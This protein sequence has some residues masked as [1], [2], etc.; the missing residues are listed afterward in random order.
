MKRTHEVSKSIF[1]DSSIKKDLRQIV[2]F[3]HGISDQ[4]VCSILDEVVVLI[5]TF[6]F[7]KKKQ[8]SKSTT[9]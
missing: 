7:D 3:F 4:K 2:A 6:I 1:Y 8:Q 9:Y 5:F